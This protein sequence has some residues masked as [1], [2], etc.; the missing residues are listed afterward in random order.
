M[1]IAQFRWRACAVRQRKSDVDNF[2]L[3]NN[4][5]NPRKKNLVCTL[6]IRYFENCLRLIRYCLPTVPRTLL[7]F[8]RIIRTMSKV[9]KTSFT[10]T[11]IVDRGQDWTRIG[12]FCSMWS[13]FRFSR[14]KYFENSLTL[15]REWGKNVQPYRKNFVQGTVL[16]MSSSLPINRLFHNHGYHPTKFP[17]FVQYNSKVFEKFRKIP[18]FRSLRTH[19]PQLS[20]TTQITQT[21]E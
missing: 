17:C 5:W 20:R 14:S 13:N 1:R 16:T 9:S 3:Q 15:V 12:I 21:I 2:L 10:E 4:Y 18:R 6:L 7:K 11:F 8:G 19:C